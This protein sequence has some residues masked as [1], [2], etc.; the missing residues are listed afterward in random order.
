[1]SLPGI[2]SPNQGVPNINCIEI[3]TGTYGSTGLSTSTAMP[4]AAVADTTS[5]VTTSTNYL[6]PADYP[7]SIEFGPRI[8]TT[9]NDNLATA[10]NESEYNQLLLPTKDASTVKARI[11]QLTEGGNTSIA[12]GMRWGTAILD[13]SATNLYTITNSDGK[14]RP[15][16]NNDATVRKIIVLM[17]DGENYYVYDA[18]RPAPRRSGAAPTAVLP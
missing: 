5:T 12:L 1:M 4:M 14:V 9:K 10:E 8:C 3:P 18:Y 7:P 16:Q 17:T 11:A 15:F 13:Q 2:S 6:P